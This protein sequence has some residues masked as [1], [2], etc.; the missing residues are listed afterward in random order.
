MFRSKE[1]VSFVTGKV[2]QTFPFKDH[3]IPYLR[4]EQNE[5]LRRCILFWP[6]LWTLI[7]FFLHACMYF[8]L[9]I[10]LRILNAYLQRSN[11]LSFSLCVCVWGCYALKH[12][13]HVTQSANRYLDIIGPTSVV[14]RLNIVNDIEP[15]SFCQSA[16]SRADITSDI[17][18]FNI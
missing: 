6:S 3:S 10:S 8:C 2:W 13:N 17:Y 1:R 5:R 9:T 12:Y 11:V 15:I 4:K 14:Y 7:R 18:R 16:L